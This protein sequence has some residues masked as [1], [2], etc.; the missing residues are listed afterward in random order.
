MIDDF[1]EYGRPLKSL[2]IR[3]KRT[4]IISLIIMMETNV[5]QIY[6]FVFSLVKKAIFYVSKVMSS[7]FK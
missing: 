7:K 5:T 3:V 6:K 2:T 4:I 1:I